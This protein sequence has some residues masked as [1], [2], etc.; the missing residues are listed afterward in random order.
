MAVFPLQHK[1]P[2]QVFVSGHL[3]LELGH[4]RVSF[5]LNRLELLS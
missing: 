4:Q 3:K 5:H 2:F 1:N